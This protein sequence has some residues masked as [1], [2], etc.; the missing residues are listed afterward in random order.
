[1]VQK[2]RKSGAFFCYLLLIFLVLV[3]VGYAQEIDTGNIVILPETDVV[4][5]DFSASPFTSI[6]GLQATT[7]VPPLVDV[8]TRRD[9]GSQLVE[10][11]ATVDVT[12]LTIGVSGLVPATQ[13]M[14]SLSQ[15]PTGEDPYDNL[16]DGTTSF[17][18]VSVPPGAARFIAETFESAGANIDL[19]M[20]TGLTPSADTEICAGAGET[21]VELCNVDMPVAGDWWI[22]VQN[23]AESAAPPDTFTLAYGVVSDDVGNMWVEGPSTV[24]AA[25]VFELN[26]FWDEPALAAGGLWYGAFTVGSDPGNLKISAV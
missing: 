7:N 26:V 11:L 14:L 20:G 17:I 24:P 22:L 16:N 23:R 1:M 18:V 25:A 15:D 5:V 10:A 12:D 6:N 21:A 4:E 2:S 3:S 19:F 9:A 13:D 8:H